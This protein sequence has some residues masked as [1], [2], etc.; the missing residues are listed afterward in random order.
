MKV[1]WLLIALALPYPDRR[2]SPAHTMDRSRPFL[3]LV[4]L[5]CLFRLGYGAVRYRNQ[6]FTSS[7]TCFISRWD[8]DA[9]EHVLIAKALLSG[10]GYVV[11]DSPLPE[12]R[13]IRYVGQPALFKAPLYEF[14][15]AGSFAIS[16]FS[17]RL[18]FP[19]QALLGGLLSGLTGLIALKVFGKPAIAWFAGLAAAICPLLVNSA[20][21]PYSENLFSF[22]FV[23][24]IWT[25]LVWSETQ[26]IRWAIFCGVMVG[27]CVLT[28]ENGVLLLAAMGAMLLITKPDLKTWRGYIAIAGL[29][30]AVVAPWTLANYAR[31]GI[32]VPVASIVGMDLAEGNNEC[33][34]SEGVFV[35]YW[36][37]GRC[38][39]LDVR[40]RLLLSTQAQVSLIPRAVRDDRVSRE[41]AIGFITAHPGAYAK[42]MFRRFWTTLLPFDPRGEQ[43]WHERTVLL[44]YWL[45]VFPAGIIG[46]VAS[47][48]PKTE[49]KRALLGLVIVLNLFSIV[50]VL[51][52]SD[53]RFRIG[54]DLL[55][56]CFAG[57]AYDQFCCSRSAKGKPQSAI[58]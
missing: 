28:R 22:L 9:L 29:S 11:D 51:Y 7:G 50:A 44:L 58:D 39:P 45:L 55:L 13:H 20:S 42:L 32:I 27:L 10:K 6:L 37:E 34:A 19:L 14:F 30:I 49:P 23:I 18:F 16:G 8:Y 56:A 15:L 1:H 54:I 47:M 36:A 4:L 26:R 40:R 17:F 12:K 35:P 33:I 52:W 21:Q 46:A 48:K 41:I 57:W 5:G 38:P 3:I 43:R 31:F 25:F 24:S 2:V 53:L